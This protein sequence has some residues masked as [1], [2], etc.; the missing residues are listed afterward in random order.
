MEAAA[1]KAAMERGKRLTK[2][3]AAK[4]AAKAAA[5]GCVGLASGKGTESYGKCP[6]LIG[7]STN[8]NMGNF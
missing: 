2:R 8:Y 3:G 5:A 1:E 4:G 7:K 6:F